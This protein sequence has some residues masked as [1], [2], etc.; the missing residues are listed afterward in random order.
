MGKHGQKKT[1]RRDNRIWV[2]R[3]RKV[4]NGKNQL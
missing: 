4:I 3:K 2:D 1:F